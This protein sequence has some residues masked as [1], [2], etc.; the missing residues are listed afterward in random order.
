MKIVC[1]CLLLID[2]S[3]NEQI[4]LREESD[5]SVEEKELNSFKNIRRNDLTLI[6]HMSDEMS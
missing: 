1:N 5:V 4:N 3:I 2:S 6:T